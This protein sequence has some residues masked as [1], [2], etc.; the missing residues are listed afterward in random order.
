M[1]ALVTGVGGFC[2]VHLIRRLRREPDVV[3]AGLDLASEQPNQLALDRYFQSDITNGAAVAAAVR[4][5][6]PDWLFHLAGVSE[7]SAAA[8]RTYEINV[9]GAL[10]F[11]EA[12]RTISPSCTVLLVGSAAEYGPV[13]ALPVTERTACRP[14]GPYGISK[15]AA[16]L[17]G[18]DYARRHNLKVSVVRPFNIIGPGVPENLVVGA[19]IARAKKA[20]GCLTPVV[21]IGDTKSKRDFVA[22]SDAVDAYVRLAKAGMRN[23]IFNI[24]SGRAH[25]IGYVAKTLLE[26]SRRAIALEVDPGL[27]SISPA[28]IVYGSYRKAARA[29]GFRPTTSLKLALRESWDAA[30]GSSE[31]G[32][33]DVNGSS[34]RVTRRSP[35][36]R[37]A[38][39]RPHNG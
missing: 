25:S 11:L 28:R 10:H 39:Q 38:A 27:V 24:C 37:T 31:C 7:N 2:G 6:N 4:E 8:S 5:F 12:V 9:I 29:I 21:K 22:V 34:D 13:D 19:L 15:Y 26:N 20:L 18:M 33:R 36:D 35:S 1:R 16:T 3:I 23:E 30:I 17:I 32:D 14:V